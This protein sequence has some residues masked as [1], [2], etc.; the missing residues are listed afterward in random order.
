M[1]GSQ[2]ERLD[3]RVDRWII[4]VLPLEEGGALGGTELETLMKYLPYAQPALRS[5]GAVREVAKARDNHARAMIQSRL[6][7]VLESCSVCAISS[8]V[9]PPK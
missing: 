3:L 4:G 8:T 1:V 5:H 9:R 6:I 2:Q 7:V